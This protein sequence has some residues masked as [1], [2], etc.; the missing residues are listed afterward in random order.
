MI[1]NARPFIRQH[2]PGRLLAGQG[3]NIRSTP[4]PSSRSRSVLCT[5]LACAISVLFAAGCGGSGNKEN[6]STTQPGNAI[7]RTAE[8][9]P[10]KLSVRVS[11]REPRLSDLVE[12]DVV[13]ESQPGVEIKPPAF[14]QAVGDFLVRDYSERPAEKAAAHMRRFHYQLEPVHA[15]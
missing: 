5:A 10:V 13:I 15:G 14:A 2:W 7:E 8:K 4:L 12:M 11:P 9:G 1:A 6:P 3:S